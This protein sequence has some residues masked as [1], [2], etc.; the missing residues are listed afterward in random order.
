MQSGDYAPGGSFMGGDQG[1]FD[2]QM[3]GLQDEEDGTEKA[4]QGRRVRKLSHDPYVSTTS[5]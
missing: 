4:T 2:I 3:A 1:V 5:D